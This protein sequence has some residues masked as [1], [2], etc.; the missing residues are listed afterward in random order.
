MRQF[1]VQTKARAQ[2]VDVTGEVRAAVAESGVSQGTCLVYS[3]H[4]TAGIT[5]NEGADP[6]VA[7]DILS[8]LDRLV[9][10]SGPYRHTEGNAAAHVKATL[11]GASRSLPVEQGR[12]VLG[13]WQAIFF[14]EF[15]GPRSRR[16]VV[17][18]VPSR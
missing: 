2:M 12:L 3:P 16:V 14:C 17:E 10:W 9:P 11:V 15:D 1:S 18:V 5:I 7:A 13:T 6:D 8:Q 4:T